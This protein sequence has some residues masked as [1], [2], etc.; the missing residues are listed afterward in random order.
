MFL[1]MTDQNKHEMIIYSQNTFNP[2]ENFMLLYKD[3]M[4][5]KQ[6][7]ISYSE[8]FEFMS[9][10]LEK[11]LILYRLMTNYDAINATD[12]KLGFV[13]SLEGKDE[14]FYFDPVYALKDLQNLVKDFNL[15]T[16]RFRIQQTGLKT[17]SFIG[18]RENFREV[19]SYDLHA[20]EAQ[21]QNDKVFVEALLDNEEEGA[22]P[23]DVQKIES[24]FNT[25]PSIAFDP[26][27]ED[28]TVPE[29]VHI[30]EDSAPPETPVNKPE[31]INS[32]KQPLDKIEQKELLKK[33]LGIES[34]SSSA[35]P[36]N[37]LNT[38][39]IS[40]DGHNKYSNLFKSARKKDEITEREKDSITLR[41]TIS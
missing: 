36:I 30:Q 39:E 7:K 2:D 17:I 18:D 37:E 13:L 41:F 12:S 28:N 8:A 31:T 34:I 3:L 5:L 1:E 24:E 14:L 15:D 9:Y 33:V 11:N 38:D 10:P 4:G 22:P 35:E 16:F 27:L 19:Y 32:P 25:A 6:K 20:N 29:T 23:V 21:Y 26:L 40:F